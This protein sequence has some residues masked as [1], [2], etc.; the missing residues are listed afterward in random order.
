[1]ARILGLDIGPT[2]LRATLIHASFRKTYVERYVAIPLTEI[3]PGMS[4]RTEV[5]EAIAALLQ[6]IGGV[7]DSVIA[8]VAGDR[9]SLRTLELPLAV[10]KR[11]GDVLPLEL[12]TLLP[13]ASDQTVIDWQPVRTTA[14]KIVVIAASALRTRI[15]EE[16][17][18]LHA[19]SIEPRELAAGAAALD[20]LAN[21]LPDLKVGPVGIVDL[22]DA[23]TD[24]CLM[25]NG[26]CVFARTLT[27]GL[28]ALPE[29]ADD[30]SRAIHQSFAAYRAAGG[31][32]LTQVY[33][34]GPGAVTI[35]AVE[36]LT[37][38]I[39]VPVQPIV[40]PRATA[41]EPPN[42]EVEAPLF[43]RATALAARGIGREKRIN[44]RSGPF[45]LKRSVG[46]MREHVGLI[47]ACAAAVLL[48]LIFSVQARHSLLVE[49]RDALQA[50]LTEVTTGMFGKPITDGEAI[51]AMLKNPRAGDPLPHFDAFDVIGAISQAVPGEIKHE[52]RRVRIEVGDDK[53]EGRLELQGTLSSI[54]ERDALAAKLEQHECFHELERGRTTPARGGDSINYQ[55]E[56]VIRCGGDPAPKKGKK[57][58]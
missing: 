50:E 56:A 20:G 38:Q 17:E 11:I 19:I 46:A 44:L 51:D 23:H 42:M 57:Q 48:S 54:E 5:R 39:S 25:D 35:G 6:V 49:E 2:A 8:G 40:L 27:I 53:R 32:E 29:Q 58:Q 13:V 7:P 15:A 10:G 22:D 9:V 52:I 3:A 14:D 24:I 33:L 31:A 36:W 45:A 34:S 26:R 4:R 47:G 43:T 21:V 12:E 28:N 16:L 37:A 1:M 55:L 18:E 41:G 30:L